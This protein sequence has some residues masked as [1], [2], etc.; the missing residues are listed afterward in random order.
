MSA[1]LG[2]A[3]PLVRS[4]EP[5]VLR[6]ILRAMARRGVDR[7]A[8][9]DVGGA[10]L[11]AAQCAW[12]P[13]GTSGGAVLVARDGEVAVAADATLYYTGELQ[14]ALRSF[15]VRPT[16]TAPYQLIL[17]AYRA[18]GAECAAR[19]E[20]DFAFVL[21]DARTGT[22]VA[23]R[24]FGAKRPL[25]CAPLGGS[26]LVASTIEALRAH[27]A[28]PSVLDPAVIAEEAGALSGSSTATVW[29]G[30]TRIPPGHSLIW[31]ASEPGRTRVEP[32][33]HPP[34][35]QD[36]ARAS[37]GTE[38]LLALLGD[39]VAERLAADGPTA[40]ALSGGWDSP[41]VF[42][43][44]SRV[45]ARAPG[46]RALHPISV[47]FPPGD[48]GRE[49]ELIESIVR[50]WNATTTWLA[51]DDIP[52][53]DR[54]LRRAATREEPFP[55]PFEPM[56]RAIARA[57]VGAGAHVVLDGNGGDQLFE[58]SSIYLADLARGGRWLALSRE[59]RARGGGARALV[60]DAI[61]PA[62][63]NAILGAAGQ[64]SAFR[65]LGDQFSRRPPCWMRPE[66]VR[67][68]DLEGREHR[69]APSRAGR[70]L[71]ATESAWQLTRP[72]LGRMA[73]SLASYTLDEGAEHRSPL[74]DGRIVRFAA[75]RPVSERRS[76]RETKRLL[77]RAMRG[78]LPPEVLAPRA[79]RTGVPIRYLTT[80]IR[81]A[82][83]FW[84]ERVLRGSMLA[85]L[86]IIDPIRL[87]E[88]YDRCIA[89]SGAHETVALY[90]ALETELWLQTHATG[91]RANDGSID[92]ATRV[93]SRA[94]HDWPDN[95]TPREGMDVRDSEGGAVRHSA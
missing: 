58:T 86:G 67:A 50:H 2:I 48:P 11:G 92:A 46:R 95:L 12:E 20:G 84:R 36:R 38:E 56:N 32:H 5:V 41:A 75:G 59:W 45:L 68:H 72:V 4:A 8:W 10:L 89:G 85:E 7:A 25:H 35:F 83:P 29:R 94:G 74:Y 23:A 43:A 81:S 1:I 77:R 39:A 91:T 69:R 65:S 54:M 93:A 71:A 62:L 19:L 3:G 53:L 15:G 88:S 63:P 22:L 73:S 55:H 76:G 6:S 13:A 66:F 31:R 90:L 26:I 44:G 61:V 80:A 47:S 37:D 82:L 27:P 28:C 79:S 60:R 34:Q 87:G 49:D 33:W 14:Q 78:L 40:L 17:A 18:W 64:S 16:G 70:S 24:D 9:R 42:A 21:W 57:A 51:S 30:I 52:A